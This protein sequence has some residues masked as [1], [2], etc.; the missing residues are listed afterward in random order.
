MTGGWPLSPEISNGN[1]NGTDLTTTAGMIVCGSATVNTKGSYTE[2]V[3]AT[4]YDA[5]WIIVSMNQ[6]SNPNASGVIG[7]YAVDIAVGASG[8]EVDILPSLISNQFCM[9][10]NNTWTT[11]GVRY[12][13]PCEIPAGSRISARMQNSVVSDTCTVQVTLFDASLFS[14]GSSVID[15][16]GF[17]AANTTGTL[18]TP[19]Q[20]AKGAYFEII[21]ATAYDYSGILVA[22]DSLNQP[23]S[24][25]DDVYLLDIAVGASGSEII[26]V[27]NTMITMWGGYNGGNAI[28]YWPLQTE[29]IPISISAGT[30]ISARFQSQMYTDLNLGITLYGIRA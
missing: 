3:A 9:G 19:N 25:Q 13:F 18:V 28:S 22:F 4:T 26:I 21:D 6:P 5:F 16:V 20:G 29:F 11:G 15:A 30:R 24:Y 7:N 12:A 14:L 17:N 2:I 23:V 1:D 27:P 10:F 8:S